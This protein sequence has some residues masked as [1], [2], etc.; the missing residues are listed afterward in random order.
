VT[1]ARRKSAINPC[2]DNA[3]LIHVYT[4][5]DALRDGVLLDVSTTAREAGIRWPVALTCAAWERC[6]TVPTGVECQDEAGRLW[7]V[8]WMLRCAIG[9]S[10]G[11]E[12][13]FAVHVRNDNRE[14]I[15]RLVQLKALSGPG[16]E[17]E[18]VITV[19]LPDED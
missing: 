7:D 19:M 1:W 10:D 11:C 8:L 14:G 5:A 13:R 4:R 3:D 9:R 12:I 2:F 15:P 16:D 17:G 18:P 6:V